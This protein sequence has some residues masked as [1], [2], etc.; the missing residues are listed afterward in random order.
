MLHVTGEKN[1]NSD[2]QIDWD[3]I[4][5][6]ELKSSTRLKLHPNSFP[7][8]VD[9]PS[10]AAERANSCS[11]S[12][13]GVLQ[14]HNPFQVAPPDMTVVVRCASPSITVSFLALITSIQMRPN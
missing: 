14:R 5:R 13:S 2:S 1:A 9:L 12:P 11:S 3:E 8:T 10:I 4:L 7:L 6:G